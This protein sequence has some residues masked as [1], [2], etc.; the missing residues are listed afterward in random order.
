MKHVSYSK[1]SKKEKRKIDNKQRKNW[2]SLVP[3]TRV[4]PDKKK[5]K[6]KNMCRKAGR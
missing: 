3:V 4:V 5:E 2:G 6:R 1:L